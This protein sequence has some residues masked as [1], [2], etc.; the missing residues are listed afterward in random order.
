MEITA[1][2]HVGLNVDMYGYT[3]RIIY[4]YVYKQVNV[5]PYISL[6]LAKGLETMTSQYMLFS[7]TI[8]Q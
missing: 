7:K 2:T 3:H 6:L 8:C 1:W 5:P 4:R